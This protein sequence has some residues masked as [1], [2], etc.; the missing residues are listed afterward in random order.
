MG[1]A[2]IS[3]A[4]TH[5][6]V[7]S[8]VYITAFAPDKGESANSLI[9]NPRP[10]AP[11]PPILPPQDGFLFLDRDKF[12]EAFA[13]DLPRREAEFLADSQ[14]SWGV[15]AL[16][17]VVVDTAWRTNPSWY[18][19]VTDDHMIPL[20]AQRMMAERAGSTVVGVPGSHAIYVSQ[21]AGWPRSSSRPRTPDPSVARTG[22]QE[23]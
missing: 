14:V 13:G 9:A 4:G 23:R 22:R 12:P 3:A 5:D 7:T 2:V 6:N 15:E 16:A 10:G 8:L 1:G 11:V 18:L 20:P 19:L 17:G 21:R